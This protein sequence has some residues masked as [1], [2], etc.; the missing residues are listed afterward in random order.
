MRRNQKT[1]YRIMKKTAVIFPGIGYHTEKPLLYYAKKLAKQSGYEITEV[2]YR[3]LF[4]D[5]KT[6]ICCLFPRVSEPWWHLPMRKS[7]V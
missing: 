5:A 3:D 7:T 1:G 2:P 6:E 4:R